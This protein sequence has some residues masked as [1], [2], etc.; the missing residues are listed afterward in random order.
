MNKN[1]PNSSTLHNRSV[2]IFAGSPSPLARALCE[3]LT[4]VRSCRVTLVTDLGCVPEATTDSVQLFQCDLSKREQVG[5]LVTS[6]ERMLRSVDLVI[7]LDSEES[8]ED[9]VER[10][11]REILG[12]VNLLTNFVP[13]LARNSS[14][15][16]IISLKN[17]SNGSRSRAFQDSQ[18]EYHD[19]IQTVLASEASKSTVQLCTISCD[20][21]H[22][23]QST[24]MVQELAQRILQTIESSRSSSKNEVI[25]L[26]SRRNL[27]EFC[28][29]NLL[30]LA[31]VG[32]DK[33]QLRKARELPLKVQ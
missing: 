1:K 9:F 22:G 10:T 30:Q 13:L 25:E 4:S 6:L 33:L 31:A 27:F 8:E 29:S 23:H 26:S 7:H 20:H 21:L 3:Q 2:L 16:R 15:G 12:F 24:G 5:Q 17:S 18:S 28:S 14:A 11:S 32:L 19:L